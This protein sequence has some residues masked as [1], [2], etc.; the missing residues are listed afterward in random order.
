MFRRFSASVE[1]DRHGAG[2]ELFFVD[3]SGRRAWM[4]DRPGGGRVELGDAVVFA[5]TRPHAVAPMRRGHRIVL[6]CWFHLEPWG[7]VAEAQLAYSRHVALLTNGLY[8]E[9][10]RAA[11]ALNWELKRALYEAIRA[12]QNA[13]REQRRGGADAPHA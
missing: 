10:Q 6:L 4:P 2:G 8:S 13:S 11:Q 9:D 5:A 1:V 12:A 7:M 3:G